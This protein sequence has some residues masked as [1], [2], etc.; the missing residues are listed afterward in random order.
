MGIVTNRQDPTVGKALDDIPFEVTDTMLTDYYDGLGLEYEPEAAIAS[1]V[2]GAADDFHAQSRF[3]QD[4]GHL[5]M[6]QEWDLRAPLRTGVPYVAHAFIEDIYRRRDRTV[7]V[8][9]MS[10]DDDDGRTV[11]E[12]RHHQSF[13]LDEPVEKVEF[14]DP[15]AKEG[16]KTF[17]RPEGTAIGALDVSIS[18]EMCGQYFHGQ[19]S[20]HTDQAASEALGFTEVVVG[21]RMTMSYVGHILERHFGDRWWRSGHLD[22]KFTNPVWPDDHLTVTGVETGPADDGP[23]RR[24]VFAWIEKQGGTVAAVANATCSARD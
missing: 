4:R 9:T 23:D 24:A 2:A 12:S 21:G 6:R 20:Y 22:L 13:L 16:A 18:L 15:A 11:M 8:T 5:W 7:V 14:R 3:T 1:M 17:T 19:R 10:L